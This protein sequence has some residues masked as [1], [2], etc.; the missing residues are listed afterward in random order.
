MSI[1]DTDLFG[2]KVRVT[3]DSVLAQRF[4]FPPF[5]V[6]N[7]R[8]GS[9][10]ERKRRWIGLGIQSELGRGAAPGGSPLPAADYSN[11]E[12]GNGAGKAIEGTA[13]AKGLTWGMTDM[14]ALRRREKGA[15]KP[16]YSRGGGEIGERMAAIQE[17]G[18]SIFDPV[19]CE[20]AY[21]WFCPPGGAILDPFAGGSVRGIVAG[22]LGRS[23]LGVD[24]REEQIEANIVQ[25]Q[26]LL[27]RE[28][29]ENVQWIAGDSLKVIPGL[30]QDAG[31]DMVFSCPPYGDLEVYSDRPDDLS[32]MPD[33]K[34]D[35]LYAAIIKAAVARLKP[36]RFAMFVVGNYRNKKGHLRDLS[37]LTIR[38]FEA[39]GAPYYNE[40]ILLTSIGSLPVRVGLA[41]NSSR[42][43]G[44]THQAA[45]VFVKGDAKLAAQAMGQSGKVEGIKG[46]AEDVDLRD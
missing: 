17:T 20:I 5:S 14:D 44:R 38:A 16:A 24:L 39:A 7:A 35:E 18:T 36:N 45:L 26:T 2:E 22:I 9:W 42:K 34:F 3:A 12:R 13:K 31:Y 25:G 27:P 19:V 41:W 40:L 43:I 6:L 11:G 15:Q 30:T 23:Y 1:E 10:Q 4:I 33:D 46:K 29:Q 32:N 37:G 21:S 28:A 8:E